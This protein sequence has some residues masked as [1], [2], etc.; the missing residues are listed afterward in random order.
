MEIS[1][2]VSRRGLLRIHSHRVF[3]SQSEHWARF[4]PLDAMVLIVKILNKGAH[5]FSNLPVRRQSSGGLVVQP[6]MCAM[7]MT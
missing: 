3:K 7:T 4:F 5:H 6:L 1:K 2:G